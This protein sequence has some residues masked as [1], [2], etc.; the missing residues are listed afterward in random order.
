MEWFKAYLK[1]FV[2]E[3]KLDE[4]VEAFKKDVFPKNA[5]GKD[6]FNEQ[7]E[8]LKLTKQQLEDKNKAIE[9]LS[10]KAESVD[11]YEQRITKLNEEYA[12][13]EKDY[14][15]KVANITKKSELEKLL[16]NHNAHKDSVDLLLG[17]YIDDVELDDGQVKDADK[18]VER[19]KE[20]RGGLFI[21][22]KEDSTNKDE[23][24]NNTK[25]INPFVRGF[26]GEN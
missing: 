17:K 19:I 25:P 4:A 18:L 13:K 20:E 22:K 5:I 1:D 9:S 3:D 2:A 8:E 6:K 7:N 10:A 24:H 15:S 26:K 11:E 12:E 16:L 23:K 21:E 14:Q